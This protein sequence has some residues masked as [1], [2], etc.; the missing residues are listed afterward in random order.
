[1]R[2]LGE[3]REGKLTLLTCSCIPCKW[4][5]T[6]ETRRKIT[7]LV[8]MEHEDENSCEIALHPAQNRYQNKSENK[9]WQGCVEEIISCWRKHEL[10]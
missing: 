7:H 9:F 6:E 4:F 8:N 10:V 1:M 3:K 2:D 5:H